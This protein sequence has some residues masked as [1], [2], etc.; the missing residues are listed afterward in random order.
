MPFLLT[1]VR[2]MKRLQHPVQQT[3]RFKHTNSQQ[4]VAR[5]AFRSHLALRE[6]QVRILAHL[7]RNVFPARV[8]QS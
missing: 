7:H 4:L 8:L 6:S 5:C 1:A 2:R 3:R